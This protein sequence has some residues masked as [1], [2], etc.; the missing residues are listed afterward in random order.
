MKLY[1]KYLEMQLKIALA[2]KKTFIISIIAK[3]ASSIFAFVSIIFLFDKFGN[4]DGY[5][6]DNIM[7]CFIVSF[8]GYSVSES[9]FRAFDRFD[10][11]LSNGEFDRILVRPRNIV[12]Q[13]LGTDI[14]FERLGKAL[15][16]MIIFIYLLVSNPELLQMDKLITIL[17]M[18]ICS[19]VLYSALFVLKAGITFFTTQSLEIMNIFTDGTRDLTQYPLD[20]Y[21]KW[22]QKFFTY[23]I[24]LALVSYYPLLYIIGK[25]E[26]K[27]YIIIPLFSIL[28][29][30][31]CYIVW[32]IGI[33]KY[34]SI[35]S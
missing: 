29:I 30:I 24:P 21:V 26:N 34:K 1:F 35:G 10:K 23:V 32:R 15:V 11:I 33:R 2:Y 27:F 18:V 4:I 6:L 25:T 17:L 28:F 16:A 7:I 13:V 14:S 20:I 3:S 12:L 31:P 8:L 22:V 19:C 5:T 9:F